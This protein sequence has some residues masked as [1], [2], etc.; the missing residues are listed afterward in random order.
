MVPDCCLLWGHCKLGTKHIAVHHLLLPPPPFFKTL[1]FI[2]VFFVFLMSQRLNVKVANVSIQVAAAHLATKFVGP[3]F[4]PR[5]LPVRT[6]FNLVLPI[7]KGPYASL[8]FLVPTTNKLYRLA[9]HL[10]MINV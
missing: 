10:T 7:D 5:L 8:L 2:F 1:Y 3:A 4:V 9:F 6:S